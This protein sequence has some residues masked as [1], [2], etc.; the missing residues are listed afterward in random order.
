MKIKRRR[1]KGCNEGGEQK[2]EEECEYSAEMLGVVDT[3][4][5]F[6]GQLL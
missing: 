3:V 5:E 6:S 2:E 1:R 4:F